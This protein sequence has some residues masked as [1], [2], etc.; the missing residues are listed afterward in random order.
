MY[1]R[2]LVQTIKDRMNEPRAL[3][4]VVVGPRQTGKS[5]ALAQAI[6]GISIPVHS[7]SADLADERWLRIE[8]QQARNIALSSG[9]ALLVVDE[10]QKIR[11]WSDVV[12][13]LWDE[14]SHSGVALK[15]FLS[16]SSSLLIGDGLSDSLMG[17]FELIHFTQWDFAEC[18]KAFGCSLDEFIFFGGYPRAIQMLPDEQRWRRYMLDSIIEPTIAQDVLQMTQIRKPI[19]MRSLFF[20]GAQYSGQELSYTKMLGQL[21]DAGNT[22]TLAEYLELLSGAGILSGLAK[23]DSKSL[24]S[25]RSSPRLMV[26][27]ASLSSA[28]LGIPFEVLLKDS[29]RWGHLVESAVGAYLIHRGEREGFDVKWW[30]EGADEVDFALLRGENIA[31]IEVKSGRVKGQRGMKEFLTRFPHA[32]RIVVGSS[33]APLGAFLLGEI[34]LFY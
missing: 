14:D 23:H 10:I 17:R 20:L 1:E 18:Q 34:P 22:T 27:D 13:A 31:A 7:V 9:E 19:L 28:S 2:A 12:K 24:R 26:H 15:V 6:E 25:R 5:T 8:W 33:E 3:I 30:R 32:R 29:A 21:Q 11:G 16:G 4:Q